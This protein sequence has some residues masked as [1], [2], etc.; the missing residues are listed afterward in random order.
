MIKTSIV[1]TVIF[2]KNSYPKLSGTLKYVD[3]YL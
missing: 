2:K 1:N 3:L